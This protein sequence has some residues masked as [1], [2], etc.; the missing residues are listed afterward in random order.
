MKRF[1]LILCLPLCSCDGMRVYYPNGR[2]AFADY[3]NFSGTTELRAKGFYFKR[4]GTQDVATPRKVLV[5]GVERG[6]Q[7]ATV[8]GVAGGAL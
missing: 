3:T 7:A 4:T 1:L 8:G 5:D 6:I 2:P